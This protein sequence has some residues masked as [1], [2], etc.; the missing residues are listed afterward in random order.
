MPKI[1]PRRANGRGSSYY[2]TQ[3]IKFDLCV[4]CGKRAE[5]T[6][7]IHPTSEGGVN[8]WINFAP[9]CVKCNNAKGSLSV[10][11]FMLNR[12]GRISQRE[13]SRLNSPSI[14]IEEEIPEL[15]FDPLGMIIK[16]GADYGI[17]RI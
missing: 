12:A 11:A 8:S 1:D 3:I 15:W 5:S 17:A 16:N 4:Y 10:L 6:D 9:T 2:R 14:N 7:H 13:A